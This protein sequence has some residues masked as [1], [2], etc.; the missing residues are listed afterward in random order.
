MTGTVTDNATII[1][2]AYEALARGGGGVVATM[3]C[4]PV[5]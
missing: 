5:E 1:R 4:D 3:F 2:S